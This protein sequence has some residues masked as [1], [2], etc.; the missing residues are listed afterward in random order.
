MNSTDQIIS[1]QEDS[2]DLGSQKNAF[3]DGLYYFATFPF[4]LIATIVI[5]V[6]G[7]MIIIYVIVK[8]RRKRRLS[9]SKKAAKSTTS[10]T[11]IPKSTAETTV[12]TTTVNE[13]EAVTKDIKSTKL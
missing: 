3:F 4:G 13:T 2:N 10:S 11:T 7:L 12:S 5:S 1:V 6:L 9:K 8:I